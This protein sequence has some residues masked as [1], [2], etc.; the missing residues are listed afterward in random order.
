M[1]RLGR[2]G[3]ALLIGFV[4]ALIAGSH[5]LAAQTSTLPTGWTNRDI[6]NPAVA[7][8]A[9]NSAGTITVRG[10]GVNIWGTSDQ[11]HFAYQAV[12]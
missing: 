5:S 12:S 7:G 9:A 3:G 1:L 2:Q 10:A 8:S 6:G 4:C 11:F